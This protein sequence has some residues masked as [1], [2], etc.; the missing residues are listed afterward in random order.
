MEQEPNPKALA[1]VAE[2]NRRAQDRIDRGMSRD[3]AWLLT[4]ME[5]QGKITIV[6]G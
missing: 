1:A 2:F 3:R 4:T 6:K 5:M